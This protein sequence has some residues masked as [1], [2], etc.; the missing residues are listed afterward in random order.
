MA[1][2][3]KDPESQLPAASKQAEVE[4]FLRQVAAMPAVKPAAGRGRL[5]FALDATA[6]RQPTWDR[7][8]QIQGEMF[9]AT[10]SLGG[11]EI[12]LVFYRGLGEC[13]ASRW[14]AR[15]RDLLAAM[16]KVSCVG[17]Q[18]Q[19]ARIVGHAISEAK[20]GRVNALV[21]VGD[22]FEESLAK[23]SQL[24]GELALLNVPAFLFH[25]GGNP[26]VAEAFRE[27][28]R[29]TRGAYCPFDS[30][31]AQQLKELL[32]AVAVFAA[33]GRK[34]LTDYSRRTGGAAL[35]LTR[36]MASG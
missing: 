15:A 4:A 1:D 10:E 34:A 9:Q 31:S 30:E 19:I 14:L 22:A 20:A 16:R 29:L 25:E 11:L 35:L 7:A 6:S 32:G 12:Q 24:A 27:I 36:Q 13:K 2:E 28:A 23:V 17:G 5:I 33:G 3:K 18:T 8:C 21:F 26:Q